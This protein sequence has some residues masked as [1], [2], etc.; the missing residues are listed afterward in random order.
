MVS[1]TYECLCSKSDHIM[2]IETILVDHST[3]SVSLLIFGVQIQFNYDLLWTD[4]FFFMG[5]YI[6]AYMC[7]GVDSD[8]LQ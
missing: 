3:S 8:T 4:V 1:T 2:N 6:P 7:S 5:F